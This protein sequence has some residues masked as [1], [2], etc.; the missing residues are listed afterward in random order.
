MQTTARMNHT[1]HRIRRLAA[2]ACL[3]VLALGACGS[4]E[5]SAQ[6][7]Y[8]QAG[9]DLKSSLA[10]LVDLDLIA[11]GT[12]GLN[13]AIE[14]VSDDVDALRDSASDAAADDVEA[15]EAS[16][17]ALKNSVSELG[18]ELSRDNLSAVG[19]SIGEV[20]ASAQAVIS[21]LSDC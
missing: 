7:Q 20:S 3:G 14:Q 4:D 16:V 2:A 5:E 8:C 19:D 11:S 9:D 10:S 6:D 1:G 18:G 17:D 21:T 13:D 15:L 12:D